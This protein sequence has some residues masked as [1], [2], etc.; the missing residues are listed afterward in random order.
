ML[1]V[2]PLKYTILKDSV[3]KVVIEIRVENVTDLNNDV[4]VNCWG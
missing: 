4:K 3:A 1:F 2:K